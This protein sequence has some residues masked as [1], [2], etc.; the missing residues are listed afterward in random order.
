MQFH[1]LFIGVTLAIAATTG[2]QSATYTLTKAESIS[3]EQARQTFFNYPPRLI[4]AA[5]SQ[6]GRDTPSTYEF[7]LTVPKDAGQPLKAVK[8]TQAKN[9]E[10]VNFEVSDSKAFIGKRFAAGPEIQ[11]A[12][13]GGDQPSTPGEVTIVFD[14][15]VQPGTT[16]TV[17]LAAQANPNWGGV[18]LFGV[19]AYPAGDNGLGQFL[20]YGRIC[21]YNN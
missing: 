8:I 6:V 16:V 17:A 7:T 3:T 9:L 1:K 15:P 20:G 13:I 14:R 18:Y 4:R 11:L 5:A 10:T 2:I 21:F 12:S 19:T